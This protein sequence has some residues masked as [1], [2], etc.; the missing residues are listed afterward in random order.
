MR[1]SRGLSEDQEDKNKG[2][3]VYSVINEFNKENPKDAVNFIH[4]GSSAPFAFMGQSV[5]VKRRVRKPK[6][7]SEEQATK[8]VIPNALIPTGILRKRYGAYPVSGELDI[9][10]FAGGVRRQGVNYSSISGLTPEDSDNIYTCLNYAE[11]YTQPLSD[12]A[13]FHENI[14]KLIR[15]MAPANYV[16][17]LKQLMMHVTNLMLMDPNAKQFADKYI[18]LLKNEYYNLQQRKF[19]G[20]QNLEK[21]DELFPKYLKRIQSLL[22]G[23]YIPFNP[24]AAFHS[25]LQTQFPVLYCAQTYAKHFSHGTKGEVIHKDELPLE[26]VKLVFTPNQHANELRKLLELRGLKHIRVMGYDAAKIDQRMV[27]RKLTEDENQFADKL[28]NARTINELKEIFEEFSKFKITNT[29]IYIN[30]IKKYFELY[31]N[32]DDHALGMAKYVINQ[33]PKYMAEVS[34]MPYG[35]IYYNLRE[36][37][38]ADPDYLKAAASAFPFDL[39]RLEQVNT[40][41]LLMDTRALNLP[42]QFW[43]YSVRLTSEA[44]SG[45]RSYSEVNELK[46]LTSLYKLL[47]ADLNDID[48]PITIRKNIEERV[49][50]IKNIFINRGFGFVEGAVY[51]N[52]LNNE[53]MYLISELKETDLFKAVWSRLEV[54]LNQLKLK[55]VLDM[56]INHDYVIP[57]KL[58]QQQSGKVYPMAAANCVKLLK[59]L[60]ISKDGSISNEDYDAAIKEIHKLLGSQIDKKFTVFGGTLDSETAEFYKSILEIIPVVERQPKLAPRKKK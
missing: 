17:T 23:E 16:R 22:T 52:V 28:L 3:T 38:Q 36:K 19:S 53:R 58:K 31:L 13:V 56:L 30:V 45:I 1:E 48:L 40:L 11:N 32:G 47:M 35:D 15:G 51:S 54:R 60:H 42:E 33:S 27:E 14:I 7:K 49:S 59:N 21:V 26:S 37:M 2:E 29:K 39:K 12:P 18:K 34:I 55:Q 24:D 46:Q 41:K 4:G 50:F 8:A 20:D 6:A 44:M 9:G 25:I 57:E 5:L 43:D 10:A